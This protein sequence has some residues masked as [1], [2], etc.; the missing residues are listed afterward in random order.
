M[1]LRQATH[2]PFR[3]SLFGRAGSPAR[4]DRSFSLA[5][6]LRSASP[7]PS[8]G[9]RQHND[10]CRSQRSLYPRAALICKHPHVSVAGG[11]VR[12]TPAAASPLAHPVPPGPRE[13]LSGPATHGSL[14]SQ[15]TASPGPALGPGRRP[16]VHQVR[17]TVLDRNC[18]FQEI[19]HLIVGSAGGYRCNQTGVR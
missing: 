19:E 1:V 17:C 15:V 6:V 11:I 7:F 12:D 2:R 10:A 3:P 16:D 13:L 9:C 5:A 14:G 8:A 4:A 18:D